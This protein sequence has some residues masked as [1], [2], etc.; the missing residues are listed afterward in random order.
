[1]I[2]QHTF[3]YSKIDR[4]ELN[5]ERLYRVSSDSLLPSVTT[6]L[7]KTKDTTHLDQWVK[8]VGKE[9]AEKIKEEA[10]TLGSFMHQNL[11]NYILGQP[12]SGSY[13]SKVLAKLIIEKGLE[14]VSVVYGTEVPL[15]CKGLYAGTTDLI[16]EHNGIISI[17]DFKNSLNSKN[18]EWIEDYFLQ[19]AAY[20]IAHNEMFG[21]SINKG[22]IMMATRDAKYQEFVIEGSE[23]EFYEGQWA[24]RLAKYYDTIINE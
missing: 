11:E 21:T 1:M 15:F 5:G 6:I 10:S 14:N 2:I 23:F 19:L 17:V 13:M 3:Q 20:A 7:S 4:V 24:R 9:K 12:M 8:N 18:K 22:V 16:A